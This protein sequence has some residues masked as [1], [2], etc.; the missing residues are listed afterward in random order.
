MLARCARERPPGMRRAGSA[1]PVPPPPR[2]PRPRTDQAGKGSAYTAVYFLVFLKVAWEDV[3]GRG[4][5][6]P[7]VPP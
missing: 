6:S 1:G 4:L 2:R 5:T 3:G 7:Q